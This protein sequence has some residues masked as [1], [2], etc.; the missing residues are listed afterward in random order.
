MEF[1]LQKQDVVEEM[2]ASPNPQQ[3]KM[4]QLITA[5]Y[6]L[7]TPPVR[8][9]RISKTTANKTGHGSS[10]VAKLKALRL[11]SDAANHQKHQNQQLQV[12]TAFNG[13][14]VDRMTYFAEL[15]SQVDGS[16]FAVSF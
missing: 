10:S 11:A 6:Q 12:V 13:G 7:L 3:I 1:K 2:I 15:Q 16:I 5:E 4:K 14:A 8:D 9:N